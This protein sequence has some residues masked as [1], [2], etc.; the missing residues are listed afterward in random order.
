MRKSKFSFL[1]SNV[2]SILHNEVLQEDSTT[3]D[4]PFSDGIL[5][6]SSSTEKTSQKPETTSQEPDIGTEQADTKTQTSLVQG[7][8]VNKAEMQSFE[9]WKE[10]KLKDTSLNKANT[11]TKSETKEIKNE[12]LKRRKNHAG[13]DCG[14]KIVEKN[15]E[16]S[17]PSHILTES[18]DD[19]MLNSCSNKVWFTIEL[20]EPIK[21]KEIQIANFELFSNVPKQFRVFASDRYI[22]SNGANIWPNKYL[23]GTFEANNTRSLQAFG[24]KDSLEY[25]SNEKND[26]IYAKYVKF[27]MISHYGN[28]HYCPLSVVRIYGASP[29]DDEDSDVDEIVPSV[30]NLSQNEKKIYKTNIFDSTSVLLTNLISVVV[31]KGFNFF[32]KLTNLNVS[33][34]SKITSINSDNDSYLISGKKN[35]DRNSILDTD[36]HRILC[37]TSSIALRNCCQC[38]GDVEPDDDD[39]DR[40]SDQKYENSSFNFY[41]NSKFCGY[42]YIMTTIVQTRSNTSLLS[43]YL[44]NIKTSKNYT[45]IQNIQKNITQ[46]SLN[47]IF[48]YISNEWLDNQTSYSFD[49]KKNIRKNKVEPL[50][51]KKPEKNE[52]TN[53]ENKTQATIKNEKIAENVNSDL[54]QIKN[55]TND[56]L[57]GFESLNVSNKSEEIIASASVP[58]VNGK[59][60]LSVRLDYRIK[61]LEL[62]MTLSSQYLEKLS[63]HYRKQMD[64][65]QKAFNLTTSALIDTIRVAD[66]RDFK[67]NDKINFIE[68]KIEKIEQNLE[69]INKIIDNVEFRTN[70]VICTVFFVLSSIILIE[71]KRCQWKKH[72]KYKNENKDESGDN[73]NNGLS[74]E[75]LIE[76]KCKELLAKQ[77]KQFKDQLELIENYYKS[78]KLICESLESET[79]KETKTQTV[80]AARVVSSTLAVVAAVSLAASN[81]QYNTANQNNE[82]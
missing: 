7:Y 60:A 30:D 51:S 55:S 53:L 77:E 63:Q 65:M 69:L 32:S 42:Y 24:P 57:N 26:E 54:R 47:N 22:Q 67:Q 58:P 4:F 75:K 31:G 79:I 33:K 82:I 48:Y 71:L 28:E 8:V 35:I 15:Q 2:W 80:A 12:I 10:M 41:S 25:K 52:P 17:N 37:F 78:N 16:A 9:E 46:F 38:F 72:H 59:D 62:N 44:N 36:M 49:A 21:I 3:T 73:K 1:L 34:P 27:E 66:E 20:C 43:K 40:I 76:E 13:L 11:L 70:L 81:A 5:P 29:N 39:D 68:K 19:Y 50:R 74:V 14:A 23:I 45:N 64:E 61:L 18:K 6:T 56:G